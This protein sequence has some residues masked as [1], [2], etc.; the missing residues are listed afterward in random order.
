M[1]NNMWNSVTPASESRFTTDTLTSMCDN[2][3]V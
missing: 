3:A 1:T 2:D